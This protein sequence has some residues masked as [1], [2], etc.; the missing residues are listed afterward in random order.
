MYRAIGLIMKEEKDLLRTDVPGYYKNKKTGVVLNR[1]MGQLAA[2][3]AARQQHM[4]F[5]ALK[6]EVAEL[7]ILV[8]KM[9][10]VLGIT[11]DE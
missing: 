11:R 10:V 5:Q 8:Q 3:K 4:E 9:C 2:I 7:R 1:N 6:I